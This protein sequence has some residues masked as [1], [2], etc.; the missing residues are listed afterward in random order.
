M[1]WDT[2]LNSILN[3]TDCNVAKIKK[4]LNTAGYYAKVGSLDK[5]E[6]VR[7]SDPISVTMEPSSYSDML[8]YKLPKEELMGIYRQLQSQGKTIE[9]LQQALL[10]V[11]TEKV[12][13]KQKIRSLEEDIRRLQSKSEERCLDFQLERK[14]EEWRQEMSNEIYSLREQVQHVDGR[15][16][17]GKI[18]V[19][20]LMQEVQQSKKHLCE[21]HDS[22][23]REIDNLKHKIWRQEEELLNHISDTRE[24]KQSQEK[25]SK[26]LRELM[27]K[28]QLHLLDSNKS[29]HERAYAEQEL[30]HL[31]STVAG[32]KE[33]LRNIHLAD[34]RTSTPSKP[35]ERKQYQ[36]NHQ[37]VTQ[38]LN[39][40]SDSTLSCT[41][42]LGDTSSDDDFSSLQDLDLDPLCI[43]DVG[44]NSALHIEECENEPR[45]NYSDED[46]SV[47]L[48]GLSDNAPELTLS[49]LS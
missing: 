11:E 19:S 39:E 45:T 48:G 15:F 33:Q 8:S 44:Y 24:L 41:L 21:E 22:L 47:D 16:S 14:M 36:K 25:S 42:S 29:V 20:S 7:F 38:S 27:S 2:Q 9:F 5:M 32:L 17:H 30:T 28:Y 10:R 1:N 43:K 23:R 35:D 46:L 26:I 31:R 13:Q 4:R 40:D 37:S 34:N 12:Q 49:D 6:H 18:T 3:D